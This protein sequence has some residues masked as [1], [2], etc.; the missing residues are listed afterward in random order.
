LMQGI[1]CLD[2][3]EG[4]SPGQIEEID[5]V[6]NEHADLSDDDFVATNVQKWL[7]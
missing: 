4:L 2:P 1:W 3:S 7:A 5:R 6:C